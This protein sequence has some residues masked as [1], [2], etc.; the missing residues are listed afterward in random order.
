LS[1][2][3]VLLVGLDCQG[4]GIRRLIRNQF[5]FCLPNNKLG[6][7]GRANGRHVSLWDAKPSQEVIRDLQYLVNRDSRLL[8][9]SFWHGQRWPLM[10]NAIAPPASSTPLFGLFG[11][12]SAFLDVGIQVHRILAWLNG[13]AP[14]DL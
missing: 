2:I 7:I 8:G 3:Q 6:R 11:E 1:A 9:R 13:P 5:D 4:T 14:A 12:G 10:R